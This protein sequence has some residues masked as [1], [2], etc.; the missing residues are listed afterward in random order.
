MDYRAI[1]RVYL[2][3]V[4]ALRREED[5]IPQEIRKEYNDLKAEFKG[6]TMNRLFNLKINYN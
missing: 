6:E 4:N 5:S 2:D 3:L 1:A